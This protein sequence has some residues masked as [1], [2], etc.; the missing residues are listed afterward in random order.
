MSLH[1]RPARRARH[2]AELDEPRPR[3]AHSPGRGG[4]KRPRPRFPARLRRMRRRQRSRPQARPRPAR[5]VR[6][7]S[8]RRP[9]RAEKRRRCSIAARVA[10]GTRR[11][12]FAAGLANGDHQCGQQAGQ[13]GCRPTRSRDDRCARRAGVHRKG[14]GETRQDVPRSEGDEVAVD[15]PMR[16]RR[17]E[18]PPHGRGGL[19]ETDESDGQGDRKNACDVSPR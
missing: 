7:P 6:S 12:S 8:G 10:S 17:C 9:G 3:A 1:R 19:G 4:E 18:K 16:P 11:N 5:T 14:A 13:P 15:A 2:P